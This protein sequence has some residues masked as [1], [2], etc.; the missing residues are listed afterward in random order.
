V[1]HQGE[2]SSLTCRQP[3]LERSI[4]HCGP[5]ESGAG[6]CGHGAKSLGGGVGGIAPDGSADGSEQRHGP[7]GDRKLDEGYG[8]AGGCWSRVHQRRRDQFGRWPRGT[9]APPPRVRGWRRAYG[10]QHWPRLRR[11]PAG[12][13]LNVLEPSGRRTAPS[14]TK[15][16]TTARQHKV[17][18]SPGGCKSVVLPGHTGEYCGTAARADPMS[19][20]LIVRPARADDYQPW[21]MLWRGYC[22]E[23]DSTV[24]DAIAEGAWRRI[25]APNEAIRCLLALS[26]EERASRV[27]Q[28]RPSPAHLEPS[29]GLL[30]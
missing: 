1:S 23:L 27:R 9:V 15:K 7:R 10:C 3:V 17:C 26:R 6:T 12:L 5:N 11:W 30:P 25:L 13:V 28:L 16:R 2:R 29:S 24:S 20:E 21:L 8:R 14:G 18:A 19:A 22:A 4:A